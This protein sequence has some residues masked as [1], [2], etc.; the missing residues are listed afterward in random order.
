MSL[1][2]VLAKALFDNAAESPEEL[3]FRKGDILMVLE[4]EQE[5]GPGW[6][7]CS[8]HGRQGIAPAN[9]L[10]LLQTAPAPVLGPETRRAPSVDSVYLSP[11]HQ[12]RTNGLCVEDSDG[13][14]LSPPSLGD[15]V[16]QS[17]GPAAPGRQGE[18]RQAEARRPRS[19]SSSGPRLRP[20]WPEVGSEGRPRSPSLRGRGGEAGSA[21][22]T[23]ASPVPL[24]ARFRSQGALVSESVYLSPSTMVRPVGEAAGE[25]AYLSPRETGVSGH[26]DVCYLVPRPAAAALPGEDVYQSPVSGAPGAGQ[27]A[28]VTVARLQDTAAVSQAKTGPESM[29]IFQTASGPGRTP[30]TERKLPSGP[31]VVQPTPAQSLKQ[32]PV[33][34]RVCPRPQGPCATPP[35]GREKISQAAARGSPLLVRARKPGV[36]GSPNFAR[37]PPP[38]APPV[39]S[40]T[41]KD[42]TPPMTTS[43]GMKPALQENPV[44]PQAKRV[45]EHQ[46]QTSK[47][48]EEREEREERSKEAEMAMSVTEKECAENGNLDDQVY[49]TPPTNRWQH[50]DPVASVEEDESIYNTPRAVPLHTDEQSEIYDVPTNALNPAS[51]FQQETYNVPAPLVVSGE[52]EEDVYSIPSLPG[53]PLEPGEIAGSVGEAGG[54]PEVYFVPSPGKSESVSEDV[55]EVDGGIY[56][57]PA[58]TLDVPT[59]RLSVSST[60]SGDVQW[61]SSLSALIQSAL[62]AA[63]VATTPSRDLATLLAEIVSV[64]KANQ[65]GD[66]APPLQQIW[67]RLADLLPALSVCGSAP[68]ADSLL[69]MVR[70]ALEDSASLLQSQSRPRLP[71]QE[72][73]SRR[74]LPALPVAEVKPMAGGMGSRKGSWIQERPLPPP[75]PVAFP[76]P[77][78]PASLPSAAQVAED[79][80]H[81]NEYAGIGL[82]PATPPSYPAGDSVGYVKL[83]GKPELCPDSLTENGTSQVIST[84][85]AR[86]SPSPPLPMSLSLEDSELLSFYSSQS[87]SHLSCLAD[88]I[89]SLF[90]S[91]QGNQP[92]RIFVSRGKSLIVTAH[93]LVFIGDT[94]A[95]LLSS[96]DLR[97]KVT[98][99]SGHL[100]QAL[101]AVVVATKGAAQNYPSVPATQEMV[102]RVA[103]L[104]QQ[105]A[106]FSGLLQR[107]AEIS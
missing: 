28:P 48:G 10:R 105:A 12:T 97:A 56:D 73:L 53:L 106:G 55:S 3:A 47:E 19:H 24:A 22:Q 75:P 4:Q 63:S 8:L 43:P 67:S 61:K 71:S 49:D 84:N 87:L 54:N 38:P 29:G 23:P 95:R 50:P 58:I 26:P 51:D 15:G 36:P 81:G 89:D 60:G 17:P 5:G 11:G 6:W 82:T 27:C 74:P 102:D 41:Q 62:S 64:W 104:S 57:M 86:T 25:A 77:P 1:S 16:Y 37:K 78:A 92:P 46:R 103:D 44:S 79:E 65:V 7:L 2:T 91:V 35:M 42:L 31:A 88:A 100:C 30:Q 70:R 33:T 96:S 99:S 93:K 59:R 34:T 90:T 98:T 76:L 40:V 68:P 20:D 83:Q 18:L 107:L 39:R 66:V 94:L 69:S 52:V 85:D 32:A 21:Y 13:V 72:S 9:R 45:Q 101:K 80:E 14:Y